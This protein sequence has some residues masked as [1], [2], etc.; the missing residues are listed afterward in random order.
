MKNNLAEQLKW[1][2][3]NMD[4]AISFGFKRSIESSKEVVTVP[5]VFD[6]TH[7]V[8]DGKMTATPPSDIAKEVNSFK[9]QKIVAPVIPPRPSA[10]TKASPQSRPSPPPPPPSFM[11]FDIPDSALMEIDLDSKFYCL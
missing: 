10:T 1:L 7:L 4:A 11:D 5:Q 9:T 8:K 2:Q 3:S 6:F